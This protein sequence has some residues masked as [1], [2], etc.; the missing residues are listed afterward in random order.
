[1]L[2]FDNQQFKYQ[3]NSYFEKEGDVTSKI[4]KAFLEDEI[5]T[6]LRMNPQYLPIGNFK[7]IPSL[8]FMQLKHI[9]AKPFE[10]IAKLETYKK[11]DFKGVKFDAVSVRN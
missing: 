10:A 3:Q 5:F 4:E 8:H 6:V 9:T 7:I 2:N 11:S 1:Q